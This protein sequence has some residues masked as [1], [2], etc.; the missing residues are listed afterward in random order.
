[1]NKFLQWL[2]EKERITY[3][4]DEGDEFE[5]THTNEENVIFLICSPVIV[6]GLFILCEML[7]LL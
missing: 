3:I 7:G 2:N 5:R 1:M 4:T 6:F